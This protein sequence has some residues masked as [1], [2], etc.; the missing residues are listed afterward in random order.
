MTSPCF[1][2]GAARTCD[3]REDEQPRP[4]PK[5]GKEWPTRYAEREDKRRLAKWSK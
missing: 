5:L 2:C 1:R 3:H 4:S